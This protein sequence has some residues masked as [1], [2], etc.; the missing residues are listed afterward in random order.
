MGDALIHLLIVVVVVA[1]IVYAV[2]WLFKLLPLGIFAEPARVILY[3]V[4]AGIIFFEGL[5]PVIQI[6]L[7]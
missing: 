2:V 6:A 1:L 3:V 7:G 4:A 5:L